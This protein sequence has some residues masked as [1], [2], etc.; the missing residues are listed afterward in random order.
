MYVPPA[1][2]QDD[3]ADLHA[4]G[5]LRRIEVPER[6]RGLLARAIVAGLTALHEPDGVAI[7]QL[8]AALDVP[9]GAAEPAA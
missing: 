1:F 9:S 2:R 3:P 7:A 4:S 5:V 6:V 8:M